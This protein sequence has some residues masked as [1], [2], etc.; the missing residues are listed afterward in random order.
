MNNLDFKINENETIRKTLVKLNNN[1]SRCLIVVK[2]NNNI[3]GTVTNGDIRR[4]LIKKP[5]TS[6]KIKYVCNKKFY[7]LKKDKA[8][9]EI[10]NI[11]LRKKLSLIP[12]IKNKQII[13]CYFISDYINKKNN[14]ESFLYKNMDAVIM[15]GG[16]GTRLSPFS[17]ILP[18]P[19]I[20]FKGKAVLDHIIE[21]FLETGIEKIFLTLNYKKNIIKSYLKDNYKDKKIFQFIEEKKRLGTASSLQLLKNRTKKNLVVINCDTILNINYQ[22]LVKYHSEEKNDL[23]L[24]AAIKDFKIPYGICT[25]TK[26]N[27]LKKISEKP[28]INILANS[29]TYLINNRLLNFIP[30]KLHYNMNEYLENLM[31]KKFKIGIYPIEDKD[32]IDTGD[33]ENL[34][35]NSF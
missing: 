16:L 14:V 13:N 33:W 6:K 28:S 4:F 27:L 31:Q 2:N 11:L 5:D 7:F 26:N 20:P 3:V 18:K 21:K 12:I 10:K 9:R 25:V 22:D 19:L 29:G 1:P 15:A 32:W 34:K 8:K 30:K 35:K 23:T 17:D 24:V